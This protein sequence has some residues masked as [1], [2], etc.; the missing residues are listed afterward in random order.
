MFKNLKFETLFILGL[1]PGGIFPGGLFPRTHF[2]ILVTKM[3]S[4]RLFFG[5][6][7]HWDI[8]YK[9]MLII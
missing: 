2:Y 4:F 8:C 1:L 3:H 6:F 5:D 7:T 9:D